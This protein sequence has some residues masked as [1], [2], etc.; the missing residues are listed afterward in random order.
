MGEKQLKGFSFKDYIT[1][2]FQEFDD[3]KKVYFK[4]LG[5]YTIIWFFVVSITLIVLAFL[6]LIDNIPCYLYTEMTYVGF[7]LGAS[8]LI[9]YIPLRLYKYYSSRNKDIKKKPPKFVYYLYVNVSAYISGLIFLT[10][11][12]FYQ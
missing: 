4:R 3:E 7:T 11:I 1:T 8:I 5:I 9:V 10:F 12:P 6:G 2:K